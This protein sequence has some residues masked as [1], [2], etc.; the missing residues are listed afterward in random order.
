[1]SGG[2]WGDALGSPWPTEMDNG[3]ANKL[4]SPFTADGFIIAVSADA[5]VIAVGKAGVAVVSRQFSTVLVP[6]IVFFPS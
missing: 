6:K 1:M 2:G 5:E 3:W 4:C